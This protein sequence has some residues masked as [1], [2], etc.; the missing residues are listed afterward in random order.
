MKLFKKNKVKIAKVIAIDF[1]GVLSEG[2]CWTP[3]DVLNAKPRLNVIKRVNE[4]SKTKFIVILTAR[5]DHLIPA[6]LVW[7]RKH[8]V[9]YH[10]I[11]NI[12]MPFDL[13]VDDK[14]MDVN[15]FI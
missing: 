9:M 3:D 2:E 12:K 11:S 4:L 8:N 10:S 1:D 13:L 6:S 7:L 14:V 15:D 5:R